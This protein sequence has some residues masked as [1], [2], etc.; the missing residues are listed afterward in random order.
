MFYLICM[1]S[2]LSLF[3][4]FFRT[5]VYVICQEGY[6]WFLFHSLSQWA[7]SLKKANPYSTPFVLMC[8]RGDFV[9][10]WIILPSLVSPGNQQFNI[11]SQTIQIIHSLSSLRIIHWNPCKFSFWCAC[12]DVCII[13]ISIF[14][15]AKGNLM[16]FFALFL[17]SFSFDFKTHVIVVV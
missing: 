12:I 17:F 7:I 11:L 1:L 16:C 15:F 8:F 14:V 5:W 2:H 13:E 10:L 6:L 3:G 4:S 9:S